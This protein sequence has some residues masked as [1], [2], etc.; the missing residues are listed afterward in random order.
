MRKTREAAIFVYRGDQYLVA[1]RT[2]DGHWN[3]IAGQIEDDE[4]FAVGAARE[5]AEEAKL[6]VP[7]VDLGIPQP[8]DIDTEY[9]PLYAPG[10]RTVT[11]QS[12]AAEA[13]ANWEP[14]L[15]HEHDT[16]R[17]CTLDEALALL[18]WPEAKE[19]LRA[20]AA[21]RAKT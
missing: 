6:S 2:R 16:Y 19:G 9:L 15:D 20:L 5:L 11:V 8:Y 7:L 18:Y 14:T 4:S 13:P 1:R 12:F 21:V 17:W 10:V 3:T